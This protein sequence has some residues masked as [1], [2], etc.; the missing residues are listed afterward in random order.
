MTLSLHWV[1][2]DKKAHLSTSGVVIIASNDIAGRFSKGLYYYGSCFNLKCLAD[3]YLHR[4][5]R[6]FCAFIDYKKKIDSV[7]R[8]ASWQKLFQHNINGKML[9][10]IYRMYDSAKSCV[11]QNHQL[12]HY[13]YSNV[14]IRQDENLWELITNTFFTVFE[15]LGRVYFAW[16]I[17]YNWSYEFAL[18]QWWYRD[19]F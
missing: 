16:L 5:K 10:I 4:S 2:Q 15:W 3:L 9:K 13:F 12:S 1:Y 17:W 14:I 11:R 19:L 8:L 6:L 7:V 18:W